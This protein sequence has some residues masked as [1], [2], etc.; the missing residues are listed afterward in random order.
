MPAPSSIIAL[1]VGGTS[2]KSGIVHPGGA[3]RGEPLVNPIESRGPADRI[4]ETLAGVITHHA[5]HLKQGDLH[6]V[7]L[8]VPGPF[9]YDTGISRITGLDKYDAIFGMNVRDALS[10]RT[11]LAV[12]FVFRNDAEAAVVGEARY[13]A[14]AAFRR[15]LGITLGTGMGSAFIADGRPIRKGTD[16]PEGGELYWLPVSGARA[17]DRFSRRG[18]EAAL[19]RAEVAGDVPAAAVAARQ[20]HARAR[21]I[22]ET[23]GAELGAFLAPHLRAFGAGALLVLGGLAAAFDLFGPALVAHVPLPVRTGARPRDAAL[24]GA[25]ELLLERDR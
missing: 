14:G 9:E 22:F 7:A 16:V 20:G 15:L 21:A 1:D 10:A 25:A 11:G 5:K 17:D 19:G 6:G 24:L 4:F 12:P 3:V 13:G 18:L 8:G 2:I 23:F